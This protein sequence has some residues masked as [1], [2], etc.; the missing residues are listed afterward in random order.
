MVWA[1]F[2]VGGDAD[3]RRDNAA[4]QRSIDRH[5]NGGV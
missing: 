5:E 2:R 4:I 1:C 3:R